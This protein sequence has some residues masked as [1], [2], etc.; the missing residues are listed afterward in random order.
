MITNKGLK[1]IKHINPGDKVLTHDNTYN[2]VL[3]TMVNGEKEIWVIRGM[4]F[5]EIR[6]TANHK[7]Y[8]REMYRKYP[9]YENGKRGSERHFRNPKWKPLKD[10]T[11]NDYLGI[12][13][14]QNGIVPT[15]DG[16]EFEWSDGR[17]TRHKNELQALMKEH[18]FWWL[19]G[20]Y[21]GDGW[22]RTQGG[23]II[24]CTKEETKDIIPHLRKCDFNYNISSESTVEKIHIPI[25]EL[26]LFVSQFGNGALNK[27][28]TSTILDLP[29]IFLRDFVEGYL[30]ADGCVLDNGVHK[31][32]TV[33]RKL[34]YGI[35]QCIAK[36]YKTPY[37]IY[38][39]N[40]SPKTV[41]EG[42]LVNQNND[43]QVV[44]K[45]EKKK[46]DEAF[47]E[48]GY[49]WFP[50]REVKNTHTTEVVYD[51]EVKDRHSYTANGTIVHNCQD[52]SL[53]GN[54][55]GMTKGSGTRSGLLWEVERLLNE[56]EELPQVLLM[57]NV[58]QV[59]SQANIAD[60]HKWQKFLED[61]GYSNYT[62]TLNA[63]D[64]GV[65]QNRNRT[66]MVSILGEYN[67]TFPRPIPLTKVIADYLEPEVDEKFYINNEK[68]QELINQLVESGQLEDKGKHGVV[69]SEQGT[70]FDKKTDIA[71]TL[72]SRDYKGFGNQGMNGVVEV[73]RK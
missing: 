47:Y 43:Y 70:K 25:K 34:A 16:I 1:E 53:A 9:T 20:R 52:L 29:V 38:K 58:P 2:D 62:D 61:K 18:S 48:D 8:T 27:Q 69:L 59:I 37:R 54:R 28:L 17:K 55:E 72:L 19:I 31:V 49:I 63:K 67:Y 33:S 24:C 56:V 21:I 45:L 36:A 12:A 57:E 14:N 13:I 4:C 30:S 6:C 42:R 50:I 71:N 51:I 7:F 32:S 15:W 3:K 73:E 46:Q 22:E 35:A 68:A 5:E 39:T 60:F 66:F 40:R 23:V 26:Q 10:L 41:I 64:Y 11:K 65:A 44:W